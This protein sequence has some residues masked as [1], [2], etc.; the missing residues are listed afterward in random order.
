MRFSRLQNQFLALMLSLALV[1]TPARQAQ[2]I[3]P[4]IALGI[5]AVSTAGITVTAADVAG[6]AIATVGMGALLYMKITAPDGSGVAVPASPG[7]QV[8]APA[9][10]GTAALQ[11]APIT[12]CQTHTPAGTSR[13][14]GTVILS[15]ASTALGACL[16]AGF[17]FMDGA[18]RCNCDLG[19]AYGSPPGAITTLQ[20]NPTCPAGY[21]QNGTICVLIDARV[22]IDDDRED[23]TRAAGSTTYAPISG[24]LKGTLSGI[25]GTTSASGDSLSFV[26]S[27]AG[28]KPSS[29]TVQA[30]A[31][32]G[33]LLTQTTQ[34]TDASGASY[35]SQSIIIIAAD[36][37]ISG[38]ASNNL[39]GY[40]DTGTTAANGGATVVS[41]PVGTLPAVPVPT[42]A[43]LFLP[44]DYNREA[45]Q[46]QIRDAVIGAGM[47]SDIAGQDIA[48]LSNAQ[49]ARDAVVVDIGEMPSAPEPVAPV[50][51][52][53]NFSPFTPT[54]CSP[55]SYTFG[56]AM[57]A[58]SHVVSLDLCPYVPTIQRIGAWAMYL[59]TAAMLFQMFTRR[60]EGGG[61]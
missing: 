6:L 3:V 15:G 45:T 7:A 55:L 29:V 18:S 36:G 39:S 2:A 22:A 5:S 47:P 41:S 56:S 31:G 1:F 34:A 28:G 17:D 20:A 26:G 14:C 9:A 32:G 35:L 44:T 42:T 30:L 10:A 12:Y 23:F 54:G 50:G 59:L 46:A 33:T 58:G 51:F 40:L 52:G 57:T 11:P 4:L 25:Q 8:P 61:D 48:T 49:T 37:S 19:C 43:P 53:A 27:G 21:Q 60:P 13:G 24:D 16:D 38:T